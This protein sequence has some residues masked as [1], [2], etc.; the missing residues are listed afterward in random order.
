[1]LIMLRLSGGMKMRD[2]KFLFGLALIF[3]VMLFAAIIIASVDVG[4]YCVPLDYSFSFDYVVGD[5]FSCQDLEEMIKYG[6]FPPRLKSE[7][8][9]K[10][11][12]DDG[13]F[14]WIDKKV[15]FRSEDYIEYF[16]EHCRG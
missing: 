1:M 6:D 3:S 4:E 2:D 14:D 12:R 13:S 5:Y 16:E 7:L 10:C 11:K 8:H 9:T 15:Y